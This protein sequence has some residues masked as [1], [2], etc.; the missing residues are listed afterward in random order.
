MLAWNV[1][2]VL[3]RE[4][5]NDLEVEGI[6]SDQHTAIHRGDGG[7]TA[8]PGAHAPVQ[9]PKLGVPARGSSIEG[10]DVHRGEEVQRLLQAQVC[11][12]EPVGAQLPMQGMQAACYLLLACDDGDENLGRRDLRD[13]CH[14]GGVGVLQRGD[15]VGVEQYGTQAS[16]S[17]AA[18]S[19]SRCRCAAI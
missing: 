4:P 7:D 3:Q 10:Q 13:A 1:Y 5:G 8:V 2:P 14:D 16:A 19:R 11:L 6:A 18:S 15:G 17:R 12:D 9:I